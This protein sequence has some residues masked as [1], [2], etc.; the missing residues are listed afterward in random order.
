MSTIIIPATGTGER[1]KRA[2]YKDLKPF[3][4]VNEEKCILDFV[5][6]CFSKNDYFYFICRSEN[7][8]LFEDFINSRN[9]SG[10]I[11]VY[12]GKKLGPV[13]AI[14][15]SYDYLKDINDDV[16]IS[17]CDFGMTWDYN[18]FREFIKNSNYN[19]VVPC[20]TGYHPHLIPVENVYACCKV[21]SN[22]NILEVIEKYNSSDRENELWSP[23]IYWFKNFDIFMKASN[24]M[25]KN[26]DDLNG[27]YYVSK[28]YNYMDNCYAYNKVN[29]FYQFGIPSDFEYAKNKLNN[30]N[31][32]NKLNIDNLVILSAG[33]GERFMKLNYKFPKPFLPLRN[34]T[35]VNEIINTFENKND[36][37]C[38]GSD[39]HNIFWENSNLNYKLIPSNKIGAAYS[40]KMGCS[41][42]EGSIFIAPCDLI[43]KYD[44]IDE[45]CDAIV[46]VSKASDFN[47]NHSKYFAWV[48]GENEKIKS[49]S[50][51]ERVSDTD[52]V[53]I[54]SF[55]VK[56]NK[57]LIKYIEKI[58]EEKFTVNGEYYLDTVFKRMVQD[59][60]N[61]KYSYV[62][63]YYSFGTPEEYRE[64]KYWYEVV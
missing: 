31:C 58:F 19:G 8:S 15:G 9:L 32:S 49:I 17:Y 30:L 63:S 44:D 16:T 23:G 5:V 41:D 38:I 45:D 39:N 10:K 48:D 51:K 11:V 3:I 62:S 57:T 35:I 43:A 52:K 18:E 1:F 61:V 33:K 2:G 59:G 36:Y 60:M 24:E 42:L 46:Y 34:S 7:V 47:Y 50:I 21:D 64:N 53:L 26:H 29:K 12:D 54:G 6:D 56:D 4:K 28:V 40:Y 20:Y 22:N 14:V 25:I 37:I 27:E 13:G 55:Y